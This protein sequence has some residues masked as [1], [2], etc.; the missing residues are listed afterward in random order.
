MTGIKPKDDLCH[1][2][3]AKPAMGIEICITDIMHYIC[4]ASGL[5][6]ISRLN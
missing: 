5:L 3:E 2:F 1:N 6:G 4:F